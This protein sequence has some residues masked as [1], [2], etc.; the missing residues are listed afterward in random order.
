MTSPTQ[1]KYL[2][3]M[4]I[5]VWVSRE[6]IVSDNQNIAVTDDKADIADLTEDAQGNQ[7]TQQA[8]NTSAS[9]LISS[10]DTETTQTENVV[11]AAKKENHRSTNSTNVNV[12]NA[13]LSNCIGLTVE[14]VVFGQGDEDATWLVV[15]ESPESMVIMENQPFAED[16]G[17]LLENM[18]KAVGLEM[19][20]KQAYLINILKANANAAKDKPM[21][22]SLHELLLD[23]IE[24]VKPSIVL[25]MGQLA[26]QNLLESK[27]PLAR[28]RG[29]PHLLKSSNV[30]AVVTYYP[31]HLLI[32]PIDKR[33]A[34]DDLKLAMSLIK[35]Q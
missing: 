27:E 32:K 21:H 34:W 29:K 30:N 31:S 25:I 9:Q 18:L 20:R 1:L 28:L 26:A 2:K 35:D 7:Q 15:G 12:D 16:S 3:A 22:D 13:S 4:G 6:L 33:K 17:I 5:P 19:P 14:H 11:V 8:H 23:T 10:I 24:K